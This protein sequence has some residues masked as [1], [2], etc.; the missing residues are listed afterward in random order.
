MGLEETIEMNERIVVLNDLHVPFHD[1]KTL[2]SVYKA[3]K[4]ANPDR[5]ILGGD[6]CDFY[7]ISTFSKDPMRRM[8]LQDEVERVQTV[9]IDIRKRFPKAD[10][11][12]IPGNHEERLDYYD[13][14]CLCV[15]DAEYLKCPSTW[16][17]AFMVVD[18]INDE[19]HFTQVPI[20]NH[21]FVYNGRLYLPN[22]T[23]SLRPRKPAKRKKG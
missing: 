2:R 13:N 19:T 12:F 6:V 15:T 23:K 8:N 4:D 17:Q 3:V 5:I 18:H 20:T 1:T 14:G 22:G 10:I 11:D 16:K 21:Q 9:L 7:S